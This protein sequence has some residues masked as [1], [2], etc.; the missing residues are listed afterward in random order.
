MQ[1]R[2]QW[3]DPNAGAQQH[4][5]RAAGRERERPPRRADL[6]NIVDLNVLMKER[7]DAAPLLL[8]ADPIGC[9][10]R[11][12][13]ERIVSSDRRLVCCRPY[14]D[15]DVLAGKRSWQRRAILRREVERSPLLAFLTRR[16]DL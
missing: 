6:Q 9:G 16:E 1:H 12:T 10:I 15:D 2:K 3:R 4:D 11:R 8:D 7:A 13:A 5:R 14:L